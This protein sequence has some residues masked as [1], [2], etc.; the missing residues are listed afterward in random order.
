LI[1]FGML[2]FEV[3]MTRRLVQGGHVLVE[4]ETM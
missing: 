4:P 3:V 2:V 1:V